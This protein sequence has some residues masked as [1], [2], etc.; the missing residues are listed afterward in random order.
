[1]ITDLREHGRTNLRNPAERRHVKPGTEVPGRVG[2]PQV[3]KGRHL[4]SR[5]LLAPDTLRLLQN[6][7]LPRMIKL[8]LCDPVQHVIKVVPF[9][10]TRSAK[11]DSGR[12]GDSL[13]ERIVRAFC[14]GNGL[15]PRGFRRLGHQRKIR[16]V[17]WAAIFLRR[18]GASAA[19][20]HTA[21]CNTSSQML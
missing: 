11:R 4:F 20:S 6:R 13:N 16:Q 5:T 21:I 2:E 1:M 9:P 14:R 18:V 17:P 3:P 7:N 15:A 19:S 12:A 8:V 10:G